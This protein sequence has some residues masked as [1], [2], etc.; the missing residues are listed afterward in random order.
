MSGRHQFSELTLDDY[1]RIIDELYEKGLVKVCLSGGDP[2]SKPFAWEIIAYLYD[3]G[4]VFDIFTNGLRLIDDI[5][6]LANYYPRLVGVSIY[7]GTAE[8]HDRIT[9]I[10]GSWEKS[11]KV[12]Q[13]LTDLAVN[14]ALKCCVM[15]PNLKSYYMVADIAQRVGAIAQ[16]ELNITDS[17]DGDKCASRY[18]RLKPEELDLVLRDSN[19]PLYVGEEAPNYGG[20]ARKLTNNAC[21]A[22]ENTFCVTPDG[23]LIPCCAFHL[24]FGYLKQ[25]SVEEALDKSATRKWW[26]G[27]TLDQYEDCGRH[28]YCDYCN[29]CPG[30]N[31]VEWETPL[32]AGENNCYLAKAR[33]SLA[34]RMMRGEDP[35]EGKQLRDRLAE[36][37]SAE[38]MGIRRVLDSK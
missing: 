24:P 4:I 10:K 2:F 6:R 22:G 30:S 15:R 35:L 31:Y 21:G 26:L 36:L 25:Q 18:L 5:E 20:N 7:S 23:S 17:I 14:M 8:V 29:L 9:R 38:P 3:K 16:F 37:P 34:Q 13:G 19:I 33:H 28:D 1:K 11:M 12:V 32:K 27:Q